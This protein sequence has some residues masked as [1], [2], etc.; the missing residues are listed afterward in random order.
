MLRYLPEGWNSVVDADVDGSRS[1]SYRIDQD[2]SRFGRAQATRRVARAVFLGSAPSAIGQAARGIESSRVRLGIVSPDEQIKVFDDPL[3]RLSK[4]ATHLY[5][6]GE[7]YWFDLQPNLRRTVED[8]AA[9]L[10]HD[11]SVFGGVPTPQA[12][13]T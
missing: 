5:S 6:G 2:N 7:R 10:Q 4:N 11:K 13:P 9:R 12:L 3:D 1:V 8:R